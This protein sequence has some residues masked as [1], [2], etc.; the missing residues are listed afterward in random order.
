MISVWHVVSLISLGSGVGGSCLFVCHVPAALR[1]HWAIWFVLLS[2]AWDRLGGALTVGN[3]HLHGLHA[4]NRSM[5]GIVGTR[6][7]SGTFSW[8]S[9]AASIVHSE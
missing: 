9:E 3:Q 8:W 5:M 6:Q 7:V 4:G 1:F 2:L